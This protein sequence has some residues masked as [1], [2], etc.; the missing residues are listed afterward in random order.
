MH[1]NRTHTLKTLLYPIRSQIF[2]SQQWQKTCA[3]VRGPTQ[4][5]QKFARALGAESLLHDD[6][7]ATTLRAHAGPAVQAWYA[8][9]GIGGFHIDAA[10]AHIYSAINMTLYFEELPALRPLAAAVAHDL[11][12]PANTVVASAFFSRAGGITGMHFDSNE[13]FTIQLRGRK[14]WRTARNRHVAWPTQNGVIGAETTPEMA[15]QLRRPFPRA[16][17]ASTETFVLKPGAMLYVPRGCWHEVEALEDS[18]SLN[19]SHHVVT[20]AD[21]LPPRLRARV[22]R[23][24]DFRRAAF[25]GD[26]T[27]QRATLRIAERLLNS[28]RPA[29]AKREIARALTIIAENGA[30]YVAPANR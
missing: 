4:R 29:L 13:N 22:I 27:Q 14:C 12:V 17:P 2:L 8:S 21:L 23:E 7:V 20:I 16:M 25:G 30:S 9:G 18:L 19:I 15:Q 28:L 11:N 6:D 26:V 1:M 5:A 24:R 3:H 10:H